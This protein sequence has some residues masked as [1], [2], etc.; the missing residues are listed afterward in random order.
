MYQPLK[1]SRRENLPLLGCLLLCCPSMFPAYK[2]AIDM[3]RS[4]RA[5]EDILGFDF[6]GTRTTGGRH[7]PIR[8]HSR[9]NRHETNQR[10]HCQRKLTH[11]RFLL[12]KT[13]SCPVRSINSPG[14]HS[15]RHRQEIGGSTARIQFSRASDAYGE[16]LRNACSSADC[17]PVGVR[18]RTSGPNSDVLA[19]ATDSI[20]GPESPGS[21]QHRP[22]HPQPAKTSRSAPLRLPNRIGRVF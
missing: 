14:N 12:R 16:I 4:V 17:D 18:I 7:R 10:N 20:I 11:L 3:Q 15:N 5:V 1:T 8:R 6:L 9:I 13:D 22:W 21:R 19:R 2:I